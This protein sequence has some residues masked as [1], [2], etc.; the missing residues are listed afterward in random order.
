MKQLMEGC[1]C[2][3]VCL[4]LFTTEKLLMLQIVLQI[5]STGGKALTF[6][7]PIATSL[8]LQVQP[9]LPLDHSLL[10]SIL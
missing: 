1:F 5:W 9:Q 2:L 4:G 6:Y 8:S 7:L 10:L 3:F